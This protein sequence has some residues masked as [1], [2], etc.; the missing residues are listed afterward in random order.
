M[1]C[2]GAKGCDGLGESAELGGCLMQFAKIISRLI[3]GK[4]RARLFKR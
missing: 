3:D 2:G 1:V 4:S